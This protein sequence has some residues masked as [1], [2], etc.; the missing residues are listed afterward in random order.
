MYETIREYLRS[1]GYTAEFLLG[2]FSLPRLHL[3]FYPVG[4]QGERFAEMYR[5][6]GTALFLARVFIGGYA[7]PEGTFLE[8]MSPEIFAAL[9][10]AGFLEHADERWQATG[11]LFPFEGF[12]ISADRAFRGQQRMPPDRDYVAGGADPTSVQFYEG[13]AKTP[14]ST[15][16]E[17]GTGSGVGALLA[18]RF[19]ERVWAVDINSRSVAYAQ[20]NCELN[21]VK[22]VTVLQSDLFSA[23]GDMRFERIVANLPFVP[24]SEN[25][26]VFA[27]GGEDGERILAGFLAG[28]AERLEPG[29]RVYGLVMGS[30]REDSP[31][32]ARIRSYLAHGGEECDVAL[33]ARKTMT[34][35]DFAFDQVLLKSSDS[36]T[37]YRWIRFF[38][39]YR[40][41]Q[42]VLGAVIVQRRR[43]PR[44]V[45]TVRRQLAGKA[46]V[47]DMDALVNWETRCVSADFVQSVL[48]TR[49]KS[50]EQWEVLSKH[51]LED[52]R[53]TT[54]SHILLVSH[55]FE[56]TIECVPW[57]VSL[58]SKANGELT[59]SQLLSAT[60]KQTGQSGETLLRVFAQLV[61]NGVLEIG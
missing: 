59:T 27:A 12:F 1:A 43:E 53:M 4:H 24:S 48:A 25:T 42:M 2:H 47:G 28:C 29:G 40:I 31:F 6:P 32:E 46:T 41:Q 50:T 13:I 10:E 52:G 18:S 3:L 45:F 38:E 37:L 58:A 56:G 33:F 20:R 44:P 34:P 9:Q 5:G 14:C 30:D 11:L 36:A 55:P 39:Q 54:I 35:M 57:I 15:L 49:P 61:S 21:G 60:Q 19:A 51:A 8:H 7:E 16:L 22:N 26:A 17:M 23:L